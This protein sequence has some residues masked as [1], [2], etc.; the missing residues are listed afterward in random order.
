MDR[1]FFWDKIAKRYSKQPIADEAAYRK[2]LRVTREYF[3]PDMEVLEF[4]CGTGST[5]IAHSPYV[6]HIQAIDISSKMIEIA[7]RKADAENVENVTFR[8]SAI[9]QFSVPDR[10]LDAVL[11]LSIL[12]LLENREEVIA[13]VYKMLKPGGIFVTNTACL[14]DTM[15][16]LY[17]VCTSTARSDVDGTFFDMA[18]Y[19]LKSASPFCEGV[20]LLCNWVGRDAAVTEMVNEAWGRDVL[21]F[22]MTPEEWNGQ[23]AY[24]KINQMRK[25]PYVEG[26]EIIMLDVDTMVQ[27]PLFDVFN[28]NFDIAFTS[29]PKLTEQHPK[30][31]HR[32]VAD[33]PVNLGYTAYRWNDRVAH[34]VDMWSLQILSPT[35][36]PYVW[37]LEQYGRLDSSCLCGDQDLIC[38]IVREKRNP[39]TKIAWLDVG[40][41]YNWFPDYDEKDQLDLAWEQIQPRLGDD[42]YRVI[43]L[44]GHLK[45]LA[46][47]IAEVLCIQ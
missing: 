1:S 12:H 7:Q 41:K 21:F 9:D 32:L 16:Y 39:F 18:R 4:G 23:F 11:G 28:S 35:W 24:H 46:P 5:A 17:I 36:K 34:F 8:R 38:V 3:Q 6:K 33:M 26:D 45:P 31:M 13:R 19:M 43:H 37:L 42:N 47:R 15:K 44:K 25:M 10:T 30:W 20:T 27:G 14:G 40:A 22:D 2:K 29:R